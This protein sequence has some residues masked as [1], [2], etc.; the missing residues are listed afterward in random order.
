M[1]PESALVSK[2]LVGGKRP[3]MFSVCEFLCECVLQGLCGS[4][5]RLLE[6]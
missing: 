4:Y 5:Y 2:P 3:H 1:R 6:S